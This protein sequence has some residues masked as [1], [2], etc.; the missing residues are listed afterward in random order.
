MTKNRIFISKMHCVSCSLLIEGEL[1]DIGVEA[2]CSYR[3]GYVDVSYD[4]KNITEDTIKSTI[5]RLGYN[6]V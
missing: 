5:E 1:M 3:G 4:E 2:T 6:V